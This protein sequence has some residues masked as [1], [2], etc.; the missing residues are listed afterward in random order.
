M[1][2]A[3][4]LALIPPEIDRL[5][6]AKAALVAA[7]IGKGVNVPANTLLDALDAYV[8]QIKTGADVSG[9]TTAVADVLAGKKFV[10]A[11]GVLR[12]GTIPSKSAAT[13][14]PKTTDQTIAA[15]QYLTGAQTIAGDANLVAANIVKG[16]T[17]FGVAGSAATAGEGT[18]T[19]WGRKI[20]TGEITFPASTYTTG[21]ISHSLGVKP[22]GI[23]LWATNPGAGTTKYIPVGFLMVLLTNS[24]Y[25]SYPSVDNS[26]YFGLS[27]M[28]VSNLVD[29]DEWADIS[30]N[31]T[32][33][34]GGVK[35]Y[36]FLLEN[37]TASKFEVTFRGNG[38]S[39][40]LVFMQTTYKYLLFGGV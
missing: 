26:Q 30:Y 17:I 24:N 38:W 27:A 4:Q 36:N 10:G 15:G 1:S 7:I 19:I 3:D 39:N 29:S 31:I 13:Y 12:E 20:Q 9:V 21:Q 35:G 32:N 34:T 28:G 14:T 25:T 6:A 22:S 16:K 33:A 23:I 11:D 2:I 40:S 5:E 18:G 37:S 8:A